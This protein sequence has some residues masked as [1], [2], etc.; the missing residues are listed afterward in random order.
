M[1]GGA[2]FLLVVG[3]AAFLLVVGGAAFSAGAFSAGAFFSAA[4]F[5]AT[6][7]AF[8]IPPALTTLCFD[9]PLPWKL[10]KITIG[11]THTKTD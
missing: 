8:S 4:S 1:V 6:A 10:H 9:S 2:A 5:R 11:P 7:A 3:G